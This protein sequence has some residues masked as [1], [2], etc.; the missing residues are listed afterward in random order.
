MSS[1]IFL[2]VYWL[3]SYGLSV[4]PYP[5]LSGTTTRYPSDT[6]GFIWY[7]QPYLHADD[8]SR[9]HCQSEAGS[10]E[11]WETMNAD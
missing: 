11:V 6:H 3:A 5:N 9:T 7:L 1:Q 4:P 2:G 8:G 10:P